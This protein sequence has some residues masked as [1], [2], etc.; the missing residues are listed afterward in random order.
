[1][2]LDDSNSSTIQFKC[3]YIGLCSGCQIAHLNT[4]DQINLKQE[5]F[6][7]LWESA[8]QT[9]PKIEFIRKHESRFR[10]RSDLTIETVDGKQNIGFYKKDSKEILDIETCPLMSEPLAKAYSK[11]REV[12]FNVQKGSIRIRVSPDNKFGL[13]IDFSNE[14]IRDLLA[15]EN[16]LKELQKNFDVIEIGQ[17]RKTLGRVDGKFKLKDPEPFS[18]FETY[19]NELNPISLP[20]NIGGFSQTGFGTNKLLI[21]EL[22]K[23]LAEIKN[24]TSLDWLE[25]CSGSGNLTFPLSSVAQS[26][27]ATELDKNAVQSLLNI[28]KSLKMTSLRVERVNIHK[29]SEQM[30][31]LLSAVNGVLADPPRSGLQ[32]FTEVLTSLSEDKLPKHFVYVSCFAETLIKDLQQIIPLGYEVMSIKGVD[33]FPHSLHCEWIVRLERN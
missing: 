32:G 9:Q 5:S 14:N 12:F 23:T 19:D 21:S 27:I 24:L 7:E 16:L 33:Q 10:H 11:L 22:L 31:S 4:Q 2:F 6:S 17:K 3:G 13:W 1:M 8:F 18:W 15:N 25:L 28:A 26:V 20:M 29:V 30:V